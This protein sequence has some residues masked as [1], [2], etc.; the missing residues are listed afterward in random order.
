MVKYLCI[1]KA[2]L[3]EKLY[4]I[5]DMFLGLISFGT[6]IFI[7]L[8]LWR[9]IFSTG[10][11][12]ISGYSCTQMIWYTII[13]ELIWFSTSTKILTDDISY[14]VKSGRIA[15]ILSKPYNYIV[16]II[17]KYFADLVIKML[18]FIP[19]GLAIGFV[20]VG[21][22]EFDIKNLLFI[23]IVFI[24][25]AFINAL[26][27]ICISFSSF[28]LDENKPFHWIYDKFILVLGVLF[29][30]ELF[31]AFMQPFIKVTPIF[32]VTYGPARLAV[33]FSS[34]VFWGLIVNQ[35]IYILI[36]LILVSLIY[37]KGV[38]KINTNGG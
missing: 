35:V 19:F 7:F 20:F 26:I 22:I 24:L 2:Y 21:P 4:Y 38:K 10:D 27:K 11:N 36:F 17:S 29:P 30:I 16:Y 9:Y 34:Q 14:D 25:S 23:L 6:M 12:L 5:W 28:W 33:N 13:T 31:P 3:L 1:F 32:V 15:C 18:I 8:N 37:K